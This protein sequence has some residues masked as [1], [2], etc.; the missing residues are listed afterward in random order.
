MK[1]QTGYWLNTLGWQDFS[2]AILLCPALKSVTSKSACD[3][4][5]H[6]RGKRLWPMADLHVRLCVVCNNHT[7][8]ESHFAGDWCR[9]IAGLGCLAPS[10]VRNTQSQQQPSW[11]NLRWPFPSQGSRAVLGMWAVEK[12]YFLYSLGIREEALGSTTIDERHCAH[13]PSLSCQML[14]LKTTPTVLAVSICFIHEAMS[15]PCS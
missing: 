1:P 2:Q 15:L 5:D 11:L 8:H 10:P 13:L 4:S 9:H 6:R 14:T 7:A 3:Y 12:I